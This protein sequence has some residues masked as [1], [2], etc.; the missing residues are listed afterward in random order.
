MLIEAAKGGHTNVVS[1]L[2]DYPNSL[3]M[4]NEAAMAFSDPTANGGP[5]QASL[6]SIQQHTSVAHQQTPHHVNAAAV[7]PGQVSIGQGG[8]MSQEQMALAMQHE[9]HSAQVVGGVPVATAHLQQAGKNINI[10]PTGQLTGSHPVVTGPAPPPPPPPPSN[11]Q[12][13]SVLR[14]SQRTSATVSGA[15]NQSLN[16]QQKDGNKV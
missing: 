8:Q 5:P 2:I 14:K 13:K 4:T 10:V 11:Q 12:N 1:I 3:V 6:G 7:H 15:T 9:Q 16:N